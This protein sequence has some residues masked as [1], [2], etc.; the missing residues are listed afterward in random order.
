MSRVRDL[1]Y[2][3]GDVMTLSTFKDAKFGVALFVGLH[4]PKMWRGGSSDSG[5]LSEM[6][7]GWKGAGEKEFKS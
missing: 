7:R 5:L 4:M 3:S 1:E 2:V 6:W